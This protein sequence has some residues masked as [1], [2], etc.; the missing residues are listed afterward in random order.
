MKKG[1]VFLLFVFSLLPQTF[2][3]NIETFSVEMSPE[4]AQVGQAL[5]I[6][7]E[8]RDKNDEIVT[9][10]VGT[11]IVF[12]ETDKEAEFPNALQENTYTFKVSDQGKVKFENAVKFKKAG[13]QSV[14]VYDLNDDKVMGLA[15]VTIGETVGDQSLD[16]DIL[17][18]E[19]GL[20]IGDN[21][22]TVSWTTKKNHKVLLIINNKDEISTTSNAEWIFEKELTNLP[23]GESTIKAVV[24]DADNKR[25][26][27][28]KSVQIKINAVLPKMQSIKIDPRVEVIANI[29]LTD[30]SAVIND[31]LT[32]LKEEKSGTYIGKITA[33]KL[34]GIYPIDIVL[35]NDLGKETKE[36][37]VEKVT[38]KKVELNAAT[39]AIMT[40]TVVPAVRDPMKITGLR[41]TQLKTKSV[42]SWVKLEKAL[43]YNVYKKLENG[44]LEMVANVTEPN[45]TV[46]I[47]GEEVKYDDF[48]V[49][50]VGKDLDGQSYE[51]DLSDPTQIQ[52]G[53]ELYFLL[54]FLSLL[55]GAGYFY[56]QRRKIS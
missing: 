11:V 35:K 52:T 1:I 44:N 16:I 4:S 40:G 42:L 34:D 55:L 9:D 38:V 31:V 32:K 2:A 18:P 25:V 33:P 6:T 21:K 26:W 39:W 54:V 36:L 19:S 48:Y 10:Y 37:A 51:W 23:D 43:S 24:L 20:T 7:I 29:G 47:V 13:K 53:P 22:I 27:E 45:F 14:H 41:L 8:A 15:E 3:A 50:A 56:F 46:N 5:D 17:S 12:S 30:V 28:S 49:K